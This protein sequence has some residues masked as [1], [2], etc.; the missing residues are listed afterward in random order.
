VAVT[1]FVEPLAFQVLYWLAA[2]LVLLGQLE[3][4]A[5]Q[6]QQERRVLQG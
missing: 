5:F 2:G 1:A 6:A 3:R 4:Q